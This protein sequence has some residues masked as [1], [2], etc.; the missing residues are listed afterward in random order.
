MAGGAALV[1]LF[2]FLD[3]RSECSGLG[4]ERTVEITYSFT[5]DGIEPEARLVYEN[6]A[7]TITF[8]D[9]TAQ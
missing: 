3:S 9:L 5:I 8:K 6:A 7:T 1:L 2:V 4:N